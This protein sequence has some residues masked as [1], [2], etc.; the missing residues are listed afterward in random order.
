MYSL[1]VL[2]P[3]VEASARAVNAPVSVAPC[4]SSYSCQCKRCMAERAIL[5]RA[6]CRDRS[7]PWMPKAA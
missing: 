1:R 7:Q 6:G 2:T 3:D 5:V 4:E